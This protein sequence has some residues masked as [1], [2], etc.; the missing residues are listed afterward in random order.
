[1]SLMRQGKLQADGLIDPVV[2]LEKGPE[3]FRLIQENPG[4]VIKYAIR[5]ESDEPRSR[6]RP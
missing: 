6:G 3:V 2:P 4:Q 5:F 1:V